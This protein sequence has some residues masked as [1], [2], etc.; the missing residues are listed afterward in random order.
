LGR[1]LIFLGSDHTTGQIGRSP[2][3]WKKKKETNNVL[4]YTAK[5]KGA[6]VKKGTGIGQVHKHPPLSAANLLSKSRATLGGG[7]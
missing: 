5:M 3:L 7:E 4:V 2:H 1:T 6:A